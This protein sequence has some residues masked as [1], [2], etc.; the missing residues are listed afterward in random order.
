MAAST[1]SIS[2]WSVMLTKD[3]PSRPAVAITF[4]GRHRCI[5]YVMRCTDAMDMQVRAIESRPCGLIEDVFQ[6]RH[7]FRRGTE[8]IVA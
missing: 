6:N 1:L 7:R 3:K 5:A 8:K 4:A 2:L